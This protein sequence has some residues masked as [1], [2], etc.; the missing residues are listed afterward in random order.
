MRITSIPIIKDSFERPEIQQVMNKVLGTLI[1]ISPLIN[2]KLGQSAP[3]DDYLRDGMLAFADGVNWLPNGTGGRG[4]W[5]WS[6][7]LNAWELC[8]TL[9]GSDTQIQFNDGGVFGGISDFTWD[10]TNL[11]VDLGPRASS[12]PTYG[13]FRVWNTGSLATTNRGI[14]AWVRATDGDTHGISSAVYPL[15]NGGEHAAMVGFTYAFGSAIG[16]S[17][18]IWGGDFHAM[19]KDDVTAEPFMRG[20][21][22]GVHPRKAVNTTAYG[23]FLHNSW[24][25]GYRA[26]R[27]IRIRGGLEDGATQA[28]DYYIHAGRESDNTYSFIVDGTGHMA[29]GKTVTDTTR[30]VD[31]DGGFF[32]TTYNTT[33]IPEADSGGGLTV[34]WN[35]SD[36]G[37]EVNF[38]N[39]YNSGHG[40]TFWQINSATPTA[41][42]LGQF[43]GVTLTDGDTALLIRRNVGGSYT[44]ERVSMGA[45]DSGGTN[46]KLLR[47]PN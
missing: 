10:K 13:R 44:L 34:S 45:A 32:R 11:V 36:G 33:T 8:E 9:G 43:E 2:E 41:V 40:F 17:C 21:E 20:I 35:K 18:G 30:R 47:V 37:A 15:W 19:S 14:F 1:W 38:Y 22:V 6:A 12:D 27:A 16:S 26:G 39:I 29:I 46:Y 5:R 42:N 4:L 31:I 3:P 25:G 23:I 24:A 28:W 7:S